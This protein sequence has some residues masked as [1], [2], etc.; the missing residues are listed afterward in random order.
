[1]SEQENFYNPDTREESVD[2]KALFFKFFRY[3]YFFVLAIILALSIAYLFN[4]F[5]QPVYE[6]SSTMMIN[7]P[8]KLDPQAMIGM[9]S[10]GRNQTNTQNEIVALKS[11][12]VVNRTI[13]K[14]DFYVSYFSEESFKTTELYKN[15]PFQVIF[16]TMRPQPVGLE[17]FL[18]PLGN[19]SFELSAT[20]ENVRYYNYANHTIDKE[21]SLPLLEFSETHEFGE[22]IETPYFSFTIAKTPFFDPGIN[23]KNDYRFVFNNIDF[24]TRYYRSVQVDPIAQNSSIVKLSLRGSNINKMVD[25]LNMVMEEYLI[26]ELEDKNKTSENTIAFIDR[27]LDVL[28]D[29]LV[30]SET[31]MKNFMTDN[32]V[33]NLES[34]S[35]YLFTSL[36]ELQNQKASLL[37]KSK[38]YDH[39]KEYVEKDEEE[40]L[41]PPA[42][43]VEDDVISGQISSLIVL[44]DEKVELLTTST[45]KNPYLSIV[46]EKISLAKKT[47]IASINNVI[48]TSN[49]TIDDIDER[50]NDLYDKIGD[51]PALDREFFNIQRQFGIKNSLYTYLLQKRSEA[52]IRLASTFPDS[53]VVD[54]AMNIG[55]SPVAPKK[56]FNN[57]IALFFGLIIPFLFI[58]L[59]DYLNDKI[60]DKKDVE[61]LTS[62]PIIG[63]IIHNTKLTN[64]VVSSAPKSSIAESFRS[65]R[66]NL[67]FMAK[68]KEKQTILVT[69]DMVSAGKTF[70]SINLATIFAMYGKKVLLM[71]FDL[72]KPK[73]YQDFGLTNTEGISSYLINKHSLDEIIQTSPVE[74]LDVIMAGPVPPNPSEL[75]ASEK[76]DEFFA[77]LKEIYDFII[78]DTPPLGLVTDAFL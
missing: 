6:V 67:Q 60:V 54:I 12:T 55:Q 14:L 27:E 34:K 56:S 32:Q 64:A 47:L 69:S 29:S 28:E 40:M 57:M 30:G 65:I 78:I 63:H 24:M 9:G 36:Y 16:D 59:K 8:E 39:L 35:N 25:F 19:N 74:N 42:M 71:G 76:T 61:K 3:W 49:I 75:I 62:Y 51:L 41:I 23:V 68:G 53:K 13:K 5:T 50:I 18:Q 4:R 77:R 2:Y 45:E 66:T 38:Y 11:Y 44:Y 21:L 43:G 10:Y 7:D 20:G 17:F 1:M 31:E 26:I 22:L 37:V 73:I 46:N 15:N 52:Q 33:M 48:N 70:V 58:F 72:R